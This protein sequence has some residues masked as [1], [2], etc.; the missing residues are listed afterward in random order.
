MLLKGEKHEQGTVHR[1]SGGIHTPGAERPKYAEEN[2]LID[3]GI[4]EEEDE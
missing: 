3:Y 2:V 4:I 1:V